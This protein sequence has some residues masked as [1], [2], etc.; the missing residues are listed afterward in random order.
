MEYGPVLQGSVVPSEMLGI[1]ES[2]TT[3]VEF[4]YGEYIAFMTEHRH[5]SEARAQEYWK[6]MMRSPWISHR[7]DATVRLTVFLRIPRK[8]YCI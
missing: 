8:V 3:T 4:E 2:S 7:G 6:A 1:H 5:V